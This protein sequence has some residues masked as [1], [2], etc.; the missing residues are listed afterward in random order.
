MLHF[1]I[2]RLE[3]GHATISGHDI[4]IFS[5]AKV[6][7]AALDP[8]RNK[9]WVETGSEE[10]IALS[11]GGLWAAGDRG[12][13][14]SKG[15][16]LYYADFTPHVSVGTTCYQWASKGFDMQAQTLET[17]KAS[18]F[19]KI[20]MT[21]FPKWYIFNRANPVETGAPYE[22]APGSTAAN[23]SA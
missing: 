23:A 21:T 4:D 6:V 17:L 8:I 10:N 15:S 18:P 3:P 19:N 7:Q 2:K 9:I 13:V 16:G 11:A 22:I 1:D 12:P 14:V 20:R 5:F